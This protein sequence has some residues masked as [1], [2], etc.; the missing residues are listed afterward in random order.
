MKI[1]S[2]FL[3]ACG[4][5]FYYFATYYFLNYIVFNIPI[6]WIRKCFC[7]LVGMRVGSGSEINMSQCIL[8]PP[9]IRVGNHTH[10]NR[11]CLIDGR[12]GIRIGDNVSVSFKV[13]LMTGSHVVDSDDFAYV[14]APIV[15]EDHAW[16]GVGATILPGV[17]VGRGAV[18]AAGAVVTK[19]VPDFAIAAGVPA[20][21]TGRRNSKLSYQCKCRTPFV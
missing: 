18:V 11:G 17:T 9:L 20:R 19:D 2:R 13:N 5:P 4:R 3:I 6:W 7:R 10:I 14:T 21:I 1:R 15:V 8:S 12:G 16:I